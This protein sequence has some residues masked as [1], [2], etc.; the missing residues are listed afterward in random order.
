MIPV[1]IMRI[2]R[3]RTILAA[4][5]LTARTVTQVRAYHLFSSESCSQRA[6]LCRHLLSA[7]EDT[8]AGSKFLWHCC[9]HGNCCGLIICTVVIALESIDLQCYICCSYK[10]QNQ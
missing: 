10:L 4:T 7:L 5:P 2:A 8:L 1:T 6:E 9:W 3:G